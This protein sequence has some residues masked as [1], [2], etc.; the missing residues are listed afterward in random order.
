[1]ENETMKRCSKNNN[2]KKQLNIDVQNILN[3][4]KIITKHT[5]NKKDGSNIPIVT[6]AIRI[7]N[8]KKVR[9]NTYRVWF[10]YSTLKLFLILPQKIF[11]LTF[12]LAHIY[13]P[14]TLFVR[15]GR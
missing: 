9:N 8:Y 15:S 11:C 10:I 3:A 14:V 1:M 7:K 5:I 12:C 6:I 13:N 4:C 2:Y